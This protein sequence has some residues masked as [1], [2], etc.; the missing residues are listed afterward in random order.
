MVVI[1]GRKI[2]FLFSCI[3]LSIL[4]F[5]ISNSNTETIYTS[6]T[7]ISG[8]VIII[9]AG[10]GY[11][12]NG[13]TSS[14]GTSEASINLSIALK[15]QELLEASGCSTLLTRSD[16][17]GIYDTDKN[18]IKEKK[19]SDLKNR[20]NLINESNSNLLVSIHLNKFQDS[21]YSGW[22]T[23]YRSNDDFSKNLALS[24]QS[25][26]NLSIQRENKREALSI[27]NKYI[28]D[29][30]SIPAVIVE[31]GF[32]SNEEEVS[33]LKTED[34]QEKISWGIYTGIMD[35]MNN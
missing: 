13:A 24:I 25:N 18:S 3:C 16:E 34:Y 33:L 10:H 15:L 35:Y 7:P 12:D 23:F 8:S 21:K 6:S 30:T 26:L 20:V 2:L 29:K 4:S 19:T 27:E 28:I 31:C 1:N 5:F 11:P 22:Q 32:L 14:D 9:D 17:N